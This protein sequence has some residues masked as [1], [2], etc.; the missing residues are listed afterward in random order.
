VASPI[1]GTRAA[2]YDRCVTVQNEAEGKISGDELSH[3][4]ANSHSAF[5]QKMLFARAVI[6]CRPT[7]RRGLIHQARY[8]VSQFNDP[9]G[10]ASG[11]WSLPDKVGDRPWPMAF[12]QSLAAGLRKMAGELDPPNEGASA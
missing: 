11:G 7:T 8:L 12:L 3:L 9:D 2:H 4:Q 6:L 10:C 1:I 5:E